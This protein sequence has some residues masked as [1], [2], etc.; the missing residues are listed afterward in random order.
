MLIDWEPTLAVV[1]EKYLTETEKGLE[2]IPFNRVIQYFRDLAAKK[3]TVVMDGFALE[4]NFEQ[5]VREV[6]APSWVVN[7][8]VDKPVL[9]RRTRVKN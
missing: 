9:I 6:G 1:K 8:K 4:K 3:E 2:E 5:F 7:V